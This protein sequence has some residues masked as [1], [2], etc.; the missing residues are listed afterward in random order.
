VPSWSE[1]F[2]NSSSAI[3][4]SVCDVVHWGGLMMIEPEVSIQVEIHP[5]GSSF[6]GISDCG[7]AVAHPVSPGRLTWA[8]QP[9]D[10][11]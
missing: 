4:I 1:H 5:A 9:G 6:V 7:R 10:L 2:S 3:C 8:H 11:I